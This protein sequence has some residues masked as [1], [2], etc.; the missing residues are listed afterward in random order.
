MKTIMIVATKNCNYARTLLQRLN[1]LDMPC[2]IAFV[3]DNPALIEKYQLMSSPNIVIDDQVVF[4]GGQENRMPIISELRNL[5]QKVI[6][7]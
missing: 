3:D 2:D 1:G 5:C 7:N 4:R 6:L